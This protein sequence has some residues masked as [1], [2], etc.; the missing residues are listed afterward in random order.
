MPSTVSTGAPGHIEALELTNF[1][2]Y[3]GSHFIG[4]FRDFTCVI[5]PN[6]AGKSNVMDAVSFVLGIK[7]ASMRTATMGELVYNVDKSDVR[8]KK[9]SVKL[10]FAAGAGK[11]VVFE[12]SVTTGGAA[13]YVVDGRNV[14]WGVYED[15]LKSFNILA[16][17]RNCLIFQG[18]VELMAH[19]S[20]KELTEMI[21][22]VAGS[23]E[24]RTKYNEMKK[25]YEEA[26]EQVRSTGRSKR[27]AGLEQGIMKMHRAEA[28]E[29][30][31]LMQRVGEL[32]TKQAMIQFYNVESGVVAT[33]KHLAAVEKVI[34]TREAEAGKVEEEVNKWKLNAGALHKQ[35]LAAMRAERA[36]QQTM[37]SKKKNAAGSAMQIGQAEHDIARLKEKIAGGKKETKARGDR[38]KTLERDLKEQEMLQKEQEKK[39]VEEDKDGQLSSTDYAEFLKIREK[40]QAETVGMTSELKTLQRDLDHHA[41]QITSLEAVERDHTRRLKDAE[42]Q[43]VTYTKKIDSIEASKGEAA[44]Q[45]DEINGELLNV[46][47]LRQRQK[48]DL[49]KK[50]IALKQISDEIA[51]MRSD[52]DESKTSLRMKQALEDMMNLFPGVKGRLCD[53]ITILNKRHQVAV[54]VALGRHMEA[55]VTDTDKTAHEC[56]KFLK[57]QRIGTMNFIPL[58]SVRG[59]DVTD[60]HR[61]LSGTAKPVVDCITFEPWLAP[62]VKYAI[63]VCIM[64]DGLEEGQRVAWNGATR[65]KVVTVDG[66]MLAK[67]GLM[68]G[69]AASMEQRAKKFDEKALDQK[70]QLRDSLVQEIRSLNMEG[71]R[72]EERERELSQQ[73]D[74]EKRKA[75]FSKSELASWTTKKAAA[76]KELAA[77]KKE[78]SAYGPK[79]KSLNKSREEVQEKTAEVQAALTEAESKIFGA[80]GKRVGIRDVREFEQKELNKEQDRAAKRANFRSVI[81]RLKTQ[82]DFET[83]RDQGLSTEELE[84]QLKAKQEELKSMKGEEDKRKK[85]ETEVD[86]QIAALKSDVEK[87]TAE[88]REQDQKIK[89]LKRDHEAKA[90]AAEEAK[91]KQ[92]QLMTLKEKLRVQRATLYL[93]C[94]ASDVRIPTKDDDP[95][96]GSKRK[97]DSVPTLP[98]KRGP[99]SHI[100]GV[101]NDTMQNA[102]YITV[103]EVMYMTQSDA[104][105]AA[106][107]KKGGKSDK[108]PSDPAKAAMENLLAIDFT[109][110]PEELMDAVKKGQSAFKEQLARLDHQIEKCQ[111]D[112]DKLA[113]NLKA[114][115]KYKGVEGKVKQ[116]AEE[117]QSAQDGQKK[118]YLKF[119]KVKEERYKKFSK[120]FE[121]IQAALTEIYAALT[122][123]TRGQGAGSAYITHD[124]LQEPYLGGV[125]HRRGVQRHDAECEVHH[126]IRS[127][128]HDAE[129]RRGGRCE[130]ERWEVGQ[131][132][133]RP[134]EGCDGES[135]GDRLHGDAGGAD[136]R[137]EEGAVGVQGAACAAGPS[138]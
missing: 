113:P 134:G 116:T 94:T 100:E 12:R 67:N 106:A 104:G 66:T 14:T 101:Y 54:T 39:W 80:F 133:V 107:K 112:I 3:K 78:S 92:Q 5:G 111:D 57:E 1:K 135:P 37:L 83:T 11:K 8:T 70:K 24:L 136:G 63:G 91:K 35:L 90:E 33:K 25:A 60:A 7:T 21:E 42:D 64:V 74:N 99:G 108:T 45:K 86:D 81:N 132:A 9:A 55:V 76:T 89:K 122:Q 97:R 95:V 129:R 69:G 105:A 137:R 127:D 2:S 121:T 138:D 51:S 109:V 120:A 103:S 114:N 61:L 10:H 34:Q 48:Q 84:K 30:H 41:H 102:K 29:Y 98:N 53:L 28:Q 62:A 65:H 118:A 77:L 46:Q 38:L 124:E 88:A 82:I 85:Q 72:A 15:T 36:A 126:G 131:N 79:L 93:R 58:S 4:P 16:S 26:S 49:E 44:Q 19:K 40:A 13:Q 68:T 47:G 27:D 52:R 123:G 96:V 110:M 130:E 20:P 71:L 50:E 23:G 59:K 87:K 125:A 73:V 117:W 22:L 75:E 18:E 32:K 17:T 6:G 43:V 115:E 128:V 31:S 56:V 119:V